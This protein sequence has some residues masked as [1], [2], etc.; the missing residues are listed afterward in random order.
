MCVEKG[1]SKPS[2]L[3]EKSLLE[4]AGALFCI[5]PIV[6]YCKFCT[7]KLCKNRRFQRNYE[8]NCK[9]CEILVGEINFSS[10]VI[11]DVQAFSSIMKYTILM[12]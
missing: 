1:V 8:M 3:L 12:F 7:K 10:L 4:M 2:T 6:M 5:K 11:I 9:S